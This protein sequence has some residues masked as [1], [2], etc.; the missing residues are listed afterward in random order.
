M[1][2]GRTRDLMLVTLCCALLILLPLPATAAQG[3]II[4][5]TKDTVEEGAEDVKKGGEYVVDKTKEGAKAVGK[6]AEKVG[7]ETKDLVTDDDDTD[8][9][10]TKPGERTSETPGITSEE[11][12]RRSMSSGTGRTDNDGLPAT[13]GELP[14]LVLAGGLAL[15][16]ARAL[17]LIRQSKLD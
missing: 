16:G 8:I 3:D 7:E 4:Q 5:G 10:R 13:A 14:L 17:K 12:E 1:N 11:R 9:E 2:E 15:A 6:G